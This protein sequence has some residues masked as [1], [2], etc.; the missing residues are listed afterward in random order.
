MSKLWHRVAVFGVSAGL[1]VGGVLSATAS[2]APLAGPGAS[3]S[4][5]SPSAA[6]QDPHVTISAAAALGRVSGY[7]LV[8]YEG[9][10]YA[11]ATIK[12]QVTGAASG[13]TVQLYAQRFPFHRDPGLL[14]TVKLTKSSQSVSFKVKPTIATHYQ[15]KLVSSS[16]TPLARSGTRTVY[17]TSGGRLGVKRGCGTGKNC[18][19]QYRFYLYLPSP[20]VHHYVSRHWYV[21]VGIRRSARHVPGKPRSL[22]LDRKAWVHKARRITGRQ[23]ERTLGFK[24]HVGKKAATWNVLAC[25]KD[26]EARDGVGLPGRHGCGSHRVRRTVKYLG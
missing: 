10:K 24:F 5:A 11:T 2:A 13:D 22:Y 1:L 15:V 20:L 14:D 23:Y 3:P 18:R 25:E 9:G 19:P 12:G 17:I 8:V 26:Q 4:A 6:S 16:G 7:V 21:Y